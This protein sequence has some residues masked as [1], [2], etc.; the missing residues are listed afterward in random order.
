MGFR[1]LV[2]FA[3]THT[4]TQQFLNCNYTPGQGKTQTQ[5]TP[6]GLRRPGPRPATPDNSGYVTLDRFGYD[7]QIGDSRFFRSSW[8]T[9]YAVGWPSQTS[10]GNPGVLVVG[11]G[12]ETGDSNW[13]GSSGWPLSQLWDDTGHDISNAFYSGDTWLWLAYGW[14]T[15]SDCLGTVGIVIAIE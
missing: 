13:D 15:S 9:T 2:C 12:G 5:R 11:S 4:T 8:E 14:A 10:S 6:Q 3:D 1:P 7:G